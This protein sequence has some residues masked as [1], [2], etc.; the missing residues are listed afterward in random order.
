M[1]PEIL[2]S[3]GQYFNFKNP[4]PEVVTVEVIAAALSKICRFTG[5]VSRFYSVA[6]HCVRASYLVPDEDRL[7]A[8]MHDAAEAFV[9]DLP[10][11]L[12]RMLPDY[13]AI[14]HE[15]EQVVA[16]RF[17]LRWPWPASVKHADLVMLATEAR[18][19]LP[20]HEPWEHV[21]NI[22]PEPINLASFSGR[23]ET[24]EKRY[25]ARYAELA[26]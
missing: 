24:W 13:M 19:L 16:E 12:K 21:A 9:V 11:P 2:L 23:P 17:G 25:L 10:T 20:R 6:E 26:R 5:H 14:D 4:D 8:L 3:N 22:T 15:V 1:K 7:E 18:D